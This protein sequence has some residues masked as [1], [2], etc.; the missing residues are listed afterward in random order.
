MTAL[1]QKRPQKRG[2]TVAELMRRQK[3]DSMSLMPSISTISGD[4]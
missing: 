4:V 2:V 3:R 1:F